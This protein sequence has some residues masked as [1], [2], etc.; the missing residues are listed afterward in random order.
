MT[1]ASANIC[2]FILWLRRVVSFVVAVG[3]AAMNVQLPVSAGGSGDRPR[4]SKAPRLN[5]QQQGAAAVAS[6]ARPSVSS[7]VD[8][9]PEAAPQQ[10][11]PAAAAVVHAASW[12]ERPVEH[13]WSSPPKRSMLHQFPFL[14]D[15][16][17][18][19]CI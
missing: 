16:V 18:N 8:V 10:A 1:P 3:A 17:P 14:F 6:V 7:R 9:Q 15:S 12:G 13:S 11:A 2:S 19:K 4:P 5:T